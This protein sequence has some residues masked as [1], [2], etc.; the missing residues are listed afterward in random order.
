MR[1]TTVINDLWC[2]YDKD[3]A[4]CQLANYGVIYLDEYGCPIDDIYITDDLDAEY[5]PR[6]IG[7]IC[8][9]E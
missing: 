9:D 3:V 8:L 1:T 6:N 2:D 4:S 7:V 5:H